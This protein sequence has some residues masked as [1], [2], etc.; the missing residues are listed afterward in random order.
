MAN[1]L[2]DAAKELMLS[3]GMLLS[4]NNIKLV[5]M[6]HTDD[7]PNVSTD[8]FLDDLLAGGRVFTSGNLASK[9]ITA[10]VFDAA[11]LAPAAAA[12]TGDGVDSLTF[13]NDTPA[14]EATKPLLIYVDSATGLPTS[15]FS[16][17]DVNVTFDAGTNKIFKVG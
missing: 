11:D 14:T 13:Y 1:A 17:Q 5:G 7:T 12:V 16:A 3:S 4:T 8:N 10:G 15:A 9:T 2:F 6:D